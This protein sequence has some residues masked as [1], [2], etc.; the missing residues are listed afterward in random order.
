MQKQD[1]TA[2]LHE[3][4]RLQLELS[5]IEFQATRTPEDTQ[6]MNTMSEGTQFTV[7]EPEEKKRKPKREMRWIRYINIF[8]TISISILSVHMY[9]H[10]TSYFYH[11]V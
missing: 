3:E 5:F 8:A 10:Q 11:V 7:V 9:G 4:R 6:D 1:S 2:G